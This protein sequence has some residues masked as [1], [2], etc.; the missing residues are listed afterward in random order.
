MH[1]RPSGAFR[2]YVDRTTGPLPQPWVL[3]LPIGA[4]RVL[5]LAWALWLVMALARW[6]K[7]AW[8]SFTTGAIWKK[9]PAP[10]AL[11]LAADASPAA[12]TEPA[13]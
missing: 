13:Q 10:P 11:V 9:Q 8:A 2:W 12:P 1:L 6:L 5:M 3:S 4:Y 7:R